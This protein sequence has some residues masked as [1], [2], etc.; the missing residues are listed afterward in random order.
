MS[1]LDRLIIWWDRVTQEI[2][3]E[4]ELC[5]ELSFRDGKYWECVRRYKHSGRHIVVVW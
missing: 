5:Y 3:H 2:G 1:L 4:D